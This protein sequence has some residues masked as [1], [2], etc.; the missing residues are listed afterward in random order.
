MELAY[1]GLHQLCARLL[2]HLERLPAPQRDALATVFGLHTG[3]APDRFLVGLATL[4]LFAEVA[5]QQPLICIVDDAQWLDD[6][7]AQ[8]LGFVARRLL[9]ER[10]VLV[11]AARTGIGDDVLAGLPETPVRGLGDSDARALLLENMHAP[12]D[13]AV[14]EQIITESHG[15]PL[16]LLELPRTW[17]PAELAGGFALP[18]SQPL[19]TKIEE[20]YATRLRLLPSDTQLLVLAAAAEPLGDPVLLH[21]AAGTLGLD[22]AAADPAV[23]SGILEVRG[24]VQFTHPLARSAAYRTAVAAERH[25][26]HLALAQAT[27]G[28]A[29]PDRR[30]WHRARAISGPDED[31]AAELERSAGRAQARGGL[32][33]AAAFLQRAAELTPDAAHRARRSLAAAQGKHR[34]GALDAALQLLALAEAGPLDEIDRARADLLRAQITFAVTRGRDAPPLLLDAAKRLESL[35]ATLA[36]ETYLD[37]FSAAVSAGRLA[38]GG[39]MAEVAE[40]VL[41]ADWGASSRES[42][43]ACDLLLDGLAVWSTEG[44]A[45]GV[46]M[47]KH[48]LSVFRAEPMSEEQALRWLWLACHTS[49][50]IADDAG[51]D[52]LTER[53][54]RLA[55]RAGALSLLPVALTERSTMQLYA[56][57]FTAATSLKTEADVVIEA[58]GSQA[59][60]HGALFL[61]AYGGRE[62]DALGLID[63]TRQ[64]VDERGEGLWLVATEWTSALL[65]NGLGRYEEALAAAQ[66]LVDRPDELGLATW[67]AP[68]L[69]EA[70]ARAGQADRAVEPM[71]W[72]TE[73]A[74][75]CGTDWALGVA[76]RARA[77]LSEGETAERLHREAIERLGRTRIHVALA[78][79]HLLYG[80]WLR[81][82]GRRTDARE[83]LRTSH[84][85][86]TSAGMEGF[87]ERARRE[88]V[89]TGEK[90][91]RRSAET[92]DELT[93][94]EEQIAMLARDGLSNPEIGAQL[95]ISARTVEWHL[96]KVF[97]KLEI[98]SRGGLRTALP[99]RDA[100]ARS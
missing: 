8:L 82:E 27:D 90:V 99:R 65:F 100:R 23:D 45:A 89:A 60:P 87:A 11:F 66:R 28:E 63:A 24:R 16:A 76:A 38:R 21:R 50:A 78:R 31:V 47:L 79:A 54:V 20:S 26:V 15:N 85:M 2:D 6:A 1:S 25:R 94:Q 68:E 51:W 35:D 39:G 14:C 84:R 34:A 64:D 81:R 18:D 67:V 9:A 43:R 58:T 49:R 52:E 4:T 93:P 62:D 36:R 7:S 46:P 73:I 55:R 72:F 56:G 88:L 69:I 75:A 32:A 83:Q 61:A 91:R 19:V 30:A 98:T 96:R 29:D 71:Q 5:E 13:A 74:Q 10:V 17:D 48:A 92:R 70:A 12:L 59:S 37:A 42:P 53:H 95:F 3:P 86:F 41:T 77:L 97:A 40:A 44:Y 22:L 80:E 57:K 33:A